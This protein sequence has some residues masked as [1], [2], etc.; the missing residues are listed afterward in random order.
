MNEIASPPDLITDIPKDE[1]FDAELRVGQYV[2]L[3]DLMSERKE[4]HK[5]ELEPLALAMAELEEMM[6][7]Q[8][9]SVSADSLA[10]KSGT[11]YKTKKESASVA[12]MEAFWAYV[13]AT[14]SWELID[15]KANVTGCR[16]F[17][18]QKIDAG[19]PP[20]GVNFSSI[21]KVN[22]RRK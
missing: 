9:N 5:K 7:A 8:L 15:R 1:P 4:A 12:D 14:G 10:T 13:V 11:F 6:L 2:K 16:E 17:I 19:N 22:V 18:E 21:N 3:R 20:P